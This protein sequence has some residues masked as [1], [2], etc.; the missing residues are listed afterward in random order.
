MKVQRGSGGIAPLILKVGARQGVV[1][2]RQLSSAL[3][4]EGNRVRIVQ[5]A[6]WAPGSF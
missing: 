4:P 2:Q 3:T 6:G 1:D 5:E